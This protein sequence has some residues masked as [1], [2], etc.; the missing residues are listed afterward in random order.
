MKIRYVLSLAVLVVMLLVSP[1][2]TQAV[3]GDPGSG[4]DANGVNFIRGWITGGDF[5]NVQD[6]YTS[7]A[8]WYET[9]STVDKQWGYWA[10]ISYYNDPLDFEYGTN[11]WMTSSVSDGAGGTGTS[12]EYFVDGIM[13]E[14]SRLENSVTGFLDYEKLYNDLS[15]TIGAKYEEICQYQDPSGSYGYEYSLYV[16]IDDGNYWDD[17]KYDSW[18]WLEAGTG[19]GGKGFEFYNYVEGIHQYEDRDFNSLTGAFSFNKTDELDTDGDGSFDDYQS[20]L[21]E[22]FD[23]D[24]GDYDYELTMYDYAGL[25]TGGASSYI[26]IDNYENRYSGEFSNRTDQRLDTD[27]DG[28]W[29]DYWWGDFGAYRTVSSSG[30]DVSDGPKARAEESL[31]DSINRVQS[32]SESWSYD[33][34]GY[35][36]GNSYYRWDADGDGSYSDD[37]YYETYYRFNDEGWNE[38][39]V[40]LTDYVSTYAN[41]YEYDFCENIYTGSF[42]KYETQ[43]ID[44]DGDLDFYDYQDKGAFYSYVGSGFDSNDNYSWSESTIWDP[45][46]EYDGATFGTY[47]YAY[48]WS[49]IGGDYGSETQYAKDTDNDGTIESWAGDD[50]WRETWVDYD[51]DDLLTETYTYASED[52]SNVRGVWNYAS[53]GSEQYAGSG[54]F[55]NSAEVANLAGMVYSR[56]FYDADE[57]YRES[58]YE[59][60]TFGVD[61][62]GTRTWSYDGGDSGIGSRIYLDTDGDTAW[63]N[64]GTHLYEALAESYDET[65]GHFRIVGQETNDYVTG[66]QMTQEFGY[67][68]SFDYWDYYKYNGATGDTIEQELWYTAGDLAAGAAPDY[69][70]L[71]Y[72]GTIADPYSSATYNW[73]GGDVNAWYLYWVEL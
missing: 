63:D 31:Y 54:E 21:F 28:N 41:R 17:W 18:E 52:T 15:G 64:Q 34:T 3:V 5:T 59:V 45:A 43:Y 24:D 35:S 16:D 23:V 48:N 60:A 49:Y 12:T 26:E 73:I 58:V 38:Q 61:R 36:G 22:E 57:G 20:Y 10:E 62:Q 6:T 70:Q 68:A 66:D 47:Q 44:N 71:I 27:G 2:V 14:E 56:D 29:N 53:T 1:T 67:S 9:F 69:G 4:T 72:T 42:E 40:D 19:E 46:G 37:Y 25:N 7:G 65:A 51:A 33:N 11:N 50:L 13:Y 39:E 55:D 30:F 32:S 8:V